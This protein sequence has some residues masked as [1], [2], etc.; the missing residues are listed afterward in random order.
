LPSFSGAAAASFDS[1]R[2]PPPPPSLDLQSADSKP[3]FGRR[4]AQ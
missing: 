4:A 1:N 2:T 3:K